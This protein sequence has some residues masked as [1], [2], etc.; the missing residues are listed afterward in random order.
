MPKKRTSKKAPKRSM[1][2]AAVTKTGVVHNQFFGLLLVAIGIGA[3][4]VIVRYFIVSTQMPTSVYL[5]Q[6]SDLIPGATK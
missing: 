5:I 6:P 3:L 4:V 2:K 1:G